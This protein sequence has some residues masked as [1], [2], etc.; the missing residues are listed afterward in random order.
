MQ[1]NIP[2]FGIFIVLGLGLLSF[3]FFNQLLYS[4][5][6][7]ENNCRQLLGITEKILCYEKQVREVRENKGIE[8][9]INYIA[10]E[11]REDETYN[12]IHM[13]LHDLGHFAYYDAGGDI[14]KAF[15]YLSP[16]IVTPNDYVAFDGYQHGVLHSFF[17]EERKNYSMQDLMRAS[18]NEYF[19]LENY[20][21]PSSQCFHAV[22]HALMYSN[23][24]DVLYIFHT[25]KIYPTK[26]VDKTATTE[27]S[28]SMPF[29]IVQFIIVEHPDHG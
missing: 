2:I 23:E 1:K 19:D 24:N 20:G 10:K 3:S 17:Y 13:V 14:Q 22:G 6:E 18:C 7:Y 28:W 29:F 4:E 11:I 8:A 5:K 15:S 27:L 26:T 21:I 16:K 12:I 25:A 9:A